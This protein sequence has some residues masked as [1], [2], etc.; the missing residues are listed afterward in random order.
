MPPASAA[1]YTSSY[2]HH[3]IQCWVHWSDDIP[4]THQLVQYWNG[5]NTYLGIAPPPLLPNTYKAVTT[6][7]R[8]FA[9]DVS[10]SQLPSHPT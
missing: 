8:A 10:A 1:P 6:S 3:S 4:F 9:A 7:G 5:T 2:Y